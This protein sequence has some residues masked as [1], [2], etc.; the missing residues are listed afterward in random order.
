MGRKKN[1]EDERVKKSFFRKHKKL[2]IMIIIIV[3]IVS[4]ISYLSARTAIEKSRAYVVRVSKLNQGGSTKNV[5][6]DG[7]ITDGASQKFVADSGSK[8]V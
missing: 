6:S 8:I 4:A 2:M 7:I 3:V 1:R 5:L